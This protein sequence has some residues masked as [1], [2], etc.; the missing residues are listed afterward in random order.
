MRTG[1]HS[2]PLHY[3]CS[4]H[5]VL[6]QKYFR[7]LIVLGN[8]TIPPTTSI[9]IMPLRRKKKTKGIR[10]LSDIE[11]GE[12]MGLWKVHQRIAKVL[13]KLTYPR[14]DSVVRK[15]IQRWQQRRD[16]HDHPT[17]GCP[18]KVR[19]RDH[20]HLL[21]AAKANRSLTLDE[22]PQSVTPNVSVRTVK[23]ILTKE[24]M[25]KWRAKKRPKLTED[26]AVERLHWALRY[27]DWTEE[28]WRWVIWSDECSVEK[29]KNP[30][31]VWVFRTAY[32]KWD[33]ECIQTYEKGG[34]VKMMVWGCFWG[35]YR[36]TI[37]PLIVSH[38]ID[39]STTISSR[40]FYPLS[41]KESEK[42]LVLSLSLWKIT[43]G[44]IRMGW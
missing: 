1:Y 17:S 34:E 6:G 43:L 21:R 11:K 31:R 37:V 22:L 24:G 5:T 12:I 4:N 2:F 7:K 16:H 42:P 18:S 41:C 44:S 26:H 27:A 40:I 39:L 30:R 19:G 23:C 15:F 25:K 9:H 20:W 28:D 32:E 33:K 35:P 14:Q 36:G 13:P 8:S 10:R 38:W 3:G 29:S